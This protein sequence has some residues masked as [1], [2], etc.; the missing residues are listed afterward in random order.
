MVIKA[1]RLFDGE[2]MHINYSIAIK[3]NMIVAVGN[4]KDFHLNGTIKR[5]N[6]N[7]CTI[8][9][10]LIEGH[11]HLFLHPY[12][13][14]KWDEQVLNESVAERTA[15]AVTH[16]QKTL[17][18][19]FTTV[20]DLGTEGAGY[21]DV[22]LK[23]A[24]EKGVVPGPRMIVATRAIVATGSYGPKLKNE[25]HTIIRGAAEADGVDA[26]I[27]EVRTQ[28]G[29]GADVIKVYADYRWGLNKKSA[30][31]FTEEELKTVVAVASSSGRKVVAHAGTEEGM[32]RCI[33]AGISNN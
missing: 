7:G 16:A 26:L 24:I 9:P 31:T 17:M 28:I 25:M 10:G 8:L 21:A 15:R 6:L 4:E 32:R 19:G 14:V 1:D 23:E 3:G 27:K 2:A 13:E 5:V 20:R 29:N 30:P 22:G 12:N 11:S 18:A 33:L